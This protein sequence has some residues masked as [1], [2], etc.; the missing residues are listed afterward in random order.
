M[1]TPN[2]NQGSVSPLPGADTNRNHVG[3]T[4]EDRAI[5]RRRFSVAAQGRLHSADRRDAYVMERARSCKAW[6]DADPWDNGGVSAAPCSR[7]VHK[8]GAEFCWQHDPEKYAARR[9]GR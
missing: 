5:F 2:A 4:D 7:L 6:V 3:L 9:A 8:V 1:S